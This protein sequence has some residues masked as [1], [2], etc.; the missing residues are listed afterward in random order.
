MNFINLTPHDIVLNDGTVYPS[1]GV[2]RLRDS[3][4]P[5]DADGICDVIF[6]SI[7][8]LP[9]PKANTRYIVSSLVLSAAKAMGRNDVVAPATGHP[10]CKRHNGNIVSVPGFIR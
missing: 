7:D 1:N 5:M 4:S 3:Y 10:D 8:N 2:A 9:A 6:G